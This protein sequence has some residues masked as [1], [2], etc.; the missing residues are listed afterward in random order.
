MRKK[1]ASQKK[2]NL[3][4]I[5]T[6]SLFHTKQLITWENKTIRGL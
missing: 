1:L 2:S 3:V 6:I 5:I 4:V